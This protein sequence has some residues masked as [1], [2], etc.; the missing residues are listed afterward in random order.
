VVDKLI[1]R[2]S[3]AVAIASTG[4]KSVSAFAMMENGK[5]LVRLQALGYQSSGKLAR[6]IVGYF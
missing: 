5:P 1:K 3:I 4:S 6:A 2:I